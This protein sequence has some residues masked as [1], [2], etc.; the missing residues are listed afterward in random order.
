MSV[1][2]IGRRHEPRRAHAAD[3]A[4]DIRDGRITLGRTG[5]RLPQ[6]HR[7]GRRRR[8]R[9]GPSST[10]TTRMRQAQ[11][12][13]EHRSARPSDRAAARRAGRHQGHLRHR[14]HADRIRLAALG[15]AH[16]APRR[17][18]GGA[19]ARRRRGDHGQDRDHRIR[20]FHTRARPATRT[21]RER[22][23]GGSSSGSAAA[24]AAGM[25]PG[26]I[27]SQTN[28]SVIRP[29]AFCGVVGFKPTHGL[30]PRTRRA[31]AVAHARSCRRVRAR[32]SR[33][34]RC[35]PRCWPVSTTRTPTR[36]R[37]APPPFVDRRGQRAAAAAALCLRPL[38]G[39]ARM[40]SRRRSEAFAE[41]VEA[42]GEP[43]DRGRARA[44]LR[45]APSSCTAS[46]WRSRW[47]TISI[48]TTSKGGDQL[49]DSAARRDRA[50]PR[51]TRR[52]NTCALV[53]AAA[54]LNAALDELFNEYDA[55]L[56]P[57]AP[58]EA[59]RGL[60]STGNPVFCSPGPISAR[61]PL[62]LPLHGDRGRVCRIGVQLVGRRGQR[63]APL[64]HGALA[65]QNSREGRKRRASEPRTRKGNHDVHT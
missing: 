15:R 42:L 41:L 2:R 59:P 64:A 7:R 1:T 60:D 13:D 53:A 61:R 43:V 9:P 49:S 33:T 16:A 20:L 44:E 18:S 31:A 39:L 24:V 54:T 23:P 34:P 36:G 25:V 55:I 4:A 46:S 45:P 30:I 27:G 51:G 17:R 65:G 6:A 50:W 63:C 26:A 56:T 40:P 5:R 22:T 10:A 8:F 32:R 19:P 12:A 48:A 28:G 37:C 57:A 21:I 35:L 14:R 11:A 52:S 47:R 62:R 3:A 29:A 38:A 58:G